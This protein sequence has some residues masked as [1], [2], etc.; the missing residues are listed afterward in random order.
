[1]TLMHVA[2]DPDQRLNRCQ[3]LG[4]IS[5]ELAFGRDNTW[6]KRQVGKMI[7]IYALVVVVS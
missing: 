4:F 3:K 2:Y 7:D 5:F 1:M 6:T